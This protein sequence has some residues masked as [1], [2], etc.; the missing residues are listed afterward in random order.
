MSFRWP[1]ALQCMQLPIKDLQFQ[2]GVQVTANLYA[3][4]RLPLGFGVI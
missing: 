3:P 1:E 2:V 4:V